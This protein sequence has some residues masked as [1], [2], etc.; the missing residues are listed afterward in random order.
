MSNRRSHSLNNHGWADPVSNPDSPRNEVVRLNKRMNGRPLTMDFAVDEGCDG[1]WITNF[2]EGLERYFKRRELEEQ[3]RV[4]W[5]NRPYNFRSARVVVRHH[6]D[7]PGATERADDSRE[8]PAPTNN[9]NPKKG[10]GI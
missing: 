2:R 4:N 5:V 10:A 6:T 1:S 3:Q 7:L 8:R 9:D